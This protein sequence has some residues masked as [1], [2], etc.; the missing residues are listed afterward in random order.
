MASYEPKQPA[1][2]TSAEWKQS[3]S[4]PK[5]APGSEEPWTTETPIW[6]VVVRGFQIFF[7]LVIAGL[8]GYLIHGYLMDAVAFGLV[9]SLFTWIIC[10]WSLVSEKVLSARKAYNIWATLSLDLFMVILWLA[11]MGANAA[12]RATFTVNV[13]VEGCYDDGSS[14]SAH[15]CTVVKRG[16]VAS[17]GGLA[18]MSGIAGLSAVQMLLFVATFAYNAH[19]FRLYYQANKGPKATHNP[20]ALE[21][22]AQHTPMLNVQQ[23]GPAP[24]SYPQYTDQQAYQSQVPVQQP[25]EQYQPTPTTSPAP[26]PIPTPSPQPYPY[27]H[28]DQQ[29]PA[30]QAPAQYAPAHHPPQQYAEAP[31]HTPVQGH[32]PA[33]YPQATQ[34]YSSNPHEMPSHSQGYSQPTSFPQ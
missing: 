18:M 14:I 9:C 20:G 33:Q 21:M 22:N 28:P 24:P 19:K 34:S 12:N 2:E 25:V 23:G 5:A 31:G 17:K 32:T 10:I 7:G 1:V 16:A 26:A 15:H 6:H 4:A 27:G 8:A 29:Y 30:Q 13:N 3:W 11:S